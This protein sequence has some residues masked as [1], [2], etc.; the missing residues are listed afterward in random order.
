MSHLHT[1]DED[2]AWGGSREEIAS[3]QYE[4]IERLEKE[5]ERLK[6]ENQKLKK[7]LKKKESK[8]PS[9]YDSES[10]EIEPGLWSRFKT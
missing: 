6:E 7:Q 5:I 4:E 9:R 1:N 8:P 2:W 10:E 3:Q